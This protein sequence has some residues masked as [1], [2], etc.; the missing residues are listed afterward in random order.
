MQAEDQRLNHVASLLK[1]PTQSKGI[2]LLFLLFLLTLPLLARL[3]L[4]LQAKQFAH[5]KDASVLFVQRVFA[6]ARLT[7]TWHRSSTRRWER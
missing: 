5:R 1:L 4:L 6:I 7:E 2:F 3:L